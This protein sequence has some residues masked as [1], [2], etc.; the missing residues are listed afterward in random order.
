MFGKVVKL[1]KKVLGKTKPR[2]A[3]EPV[4]LARDAHDVSRRDISEAALKVLYRLK[5]EGYAAYLVGGGVRDILLGLHPKDF[6][7]ATDATPEQVKQLFRNCRVIGR[8]FKLAHV[9]FGPEVIEVA[10]FRAQTEDGDRHQSEQGMLL[11]DNVYGSIEDDALRRDFTINALYYNI[12]DFSVVDFVGGLEDLDKRQLRM[13]GDPEVRFREDPVRMLRAARLAAKLDLSI[14]A[15]TAAPMPKMAVLLRE[16]SSARLFDESAKLFLMG[17]GAATYRALQANGLFAE[18]YPATAKAVKQDES[19]RVERMLLLALGNTD[20]RVAEDRPVTAGFLYAALLWHPVQNAFEKRLARNEAPAEAFQHAV[21]E[22]LDKQCQHTAIPRHYST[23]MREIWTL[24]HRLP[25]RAGKR[26]ERLFE[27]PRFRAAYDF[28]LLRAEIGEAD[29][30][31]ADWWTD[32]QEADGRGR[33][34]LLKTLAATGEKAPAARR[35]RGPRKK[36]APATH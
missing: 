4:V 18:L 34:A 17:A 22:V 29:Q 27:H 7:I 33:E 6:D 19:G 15:G 13:I 9:V 1:A 32:W 28:L 14:E 36:P 24:Q 16:V 8:R 31:L 5:K 23:M 30:E 26:A 12:A 25:Q 10:T 3:H 11:R 20:A 35:R 21:S 2:T